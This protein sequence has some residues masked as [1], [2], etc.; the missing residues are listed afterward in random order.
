MMMITKGSAAVNGAWRWESDDLSIWLAKPGNEG[1]KIKF[2]AEILLNQTTLEKFF[3]MELDHGSS[4][5]FVIYK[6][7]PMTQRL[8]TQVCI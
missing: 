6:E 5:K 7:R 4:S 3:S 8:N 1:S 2:K